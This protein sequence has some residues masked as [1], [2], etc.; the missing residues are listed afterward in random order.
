METLD[1]LIARIRETDD[2]DLREEIK[3]EMVAFAEQTS[4]SDVREYLETA[5]KEELLEVQWELE[6]VI[7]T[8]QPPKQQTEPEPEPEVDDPATRALRPSEIELVYND[9]R[10]I[11]LYKSKIDDRWVVSQIDPRINQPVTY[12]LPGSEAENI[13]AQLEGSPYWLKQV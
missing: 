9:P 5:I 4:K 1:A 8:L 6:E 3:A 7:E 13:K 10:G 2:D 11:R 12:E